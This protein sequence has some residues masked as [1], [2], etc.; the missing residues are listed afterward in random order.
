MPAEMKFFV[1]RGDVVVARD[2][3][4]AGFA[5]AGFHRGLL[6]F[7]FHRSFSF[8]VCCAGEPPAPAGFTL[9]VRGALHDT[10]SGGAAG[11]DVFG[12]EIGELINTGTAEFISVGWRAECFCGL[13]QDLNSAQIP[14]R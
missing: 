12:E 14:L 11:A 5:V 8:R 9:H 2:T 4:S 3:F 6:P 13:P 1:F 10:A 7:V